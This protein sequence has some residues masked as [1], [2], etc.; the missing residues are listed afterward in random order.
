VGDQH[1]RDPGLAVEALQDL[2]DLDAG[3]AVQVA[4]GLVGQD[5]LGLVHEG[6]RDGH[7]LLLAAGELV[8]SVVG[9]AA[10]PDRLEEGAGPA[11]ALGGWPV[12]PVVDEGQL[13]V[14]EGGRPGQQVEALEDEADRPIAQDG[15]AIAVE[16]RHVFPGQPVVSGGRL[17]Q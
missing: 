8:G 1:H 11:M 5:Q 3:P 9:A 6:P 12:F 15:A 2:H 10:Q 13:H 14:L 7:P 17:V 4:G 16:A